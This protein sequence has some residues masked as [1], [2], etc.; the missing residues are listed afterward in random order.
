MFWNCRP[1]RQ[2][3]GGVHRRA[4]LVPHRAA[5]HDRRLAL[6]D[7]PVVV[8]PAA[9]DVE[10]LQG[11][12]RR[13]DLGVAARAL[14][15]LPVLGQLLADRR[16]AADVRL[17]GRDVRGGLGRRRAQDAVQHPGPAQDR[18][19]RGAVGRHLQHAGHRQHAAAVAVRRQRDLAEL[20]ARRRR[21]CRSASPAGR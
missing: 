15:P 21:G 1:V 16:G 12:A 6:A 5:V 10:A 2:H 11:E 20:P 13:I 8:A 3:V 19:R 18:R 17:D 7:A 14:G 4:F 9:D